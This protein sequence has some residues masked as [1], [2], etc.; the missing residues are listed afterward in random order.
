MTRPYVLTRSAAADLRNI[1]RYTVEHWGHAQCRSYI[2]DL[3]A[4]AGE[5]ALGIGVFRKH[6]D[7]LPG[8]RVRLV[9]HHYL[10]CLPR[11]GQPALIL[12]ILHERMDIIA[13]L[14]ERLD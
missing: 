14:K 13:R 10:F 8:L 3:E 2:A 4:A 6:D 5:V 12:A 1:V 11:S 7:L 9:G